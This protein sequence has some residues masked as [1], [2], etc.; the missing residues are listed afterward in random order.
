MPRRMFSL[1]PDPTLRGRT[2]PDPCQT[3]PAACGAV[4][5]RRRGLRTLSLPLA[6]GQRQKHSE[7]TTPHSQPQGSFCP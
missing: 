5:G 2:L 4:P 7:E 1:W 3:L 6:T